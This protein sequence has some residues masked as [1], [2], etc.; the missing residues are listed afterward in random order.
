MP[1]GEIRVGDEMAKVKEALGSPTSKGDEGW[2]YEISPVEQ[3]LFEERD[4]KVYL[5]KW[6]EFLDL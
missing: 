6:Y 5:M 1:F 3:L 4:G 2:V